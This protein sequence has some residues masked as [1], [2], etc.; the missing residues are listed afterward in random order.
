MRVETLM[1]H[2]SSAQLNSVRGIIWFRSDV[3]TDRGA[4]SFKL[5]I[6][7]PPLM[8][9]IRT[10]PL[11]GCSFAS[12]PR[13]TIIRGAL[14]KVELYQLFIAYHQHKHET[15][16]PREGGR[17]LQIPPRLWKHHIPGSLLRTVKSAPEPT[18]NPVSLQ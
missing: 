10:G 15:R 8:R 4:S 7:H 2:I 17:R 1:A 14:Y 6:G 13:R 12:S 9:I 16:Q 5:K 11:Q 18:R 3:R